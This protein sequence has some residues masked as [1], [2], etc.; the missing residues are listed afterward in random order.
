MNSSEVAAIVLAAGRGTRFGREPKLLASAGGQALIRRP[1]EAAIAA[2]LSPIL[3]VLGHR[4]PE[5]HQAIDDLPVQIVLNPKYAEGLS[6]SVQAGFSALP[7][8]EQPDEEE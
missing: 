7:P 5:M 6:T 8:E 4:A 3:V 2:G 1:I